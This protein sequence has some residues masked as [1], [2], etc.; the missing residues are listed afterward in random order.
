MDRGLDGIELEQP[1]AASLR[2]EM[3]EARLFAASLRR[4]T[5]GALLKREKHPSHHA[6]A[7]HPCKEEAKALSAAQDLEEQLPD[8]NAARKAIALYEKAAMC[9]KDPAM[10]A[11]A[12]YRGAM[13][14]L[15]QGDCA[16]AL[17]ALEHL[18]EGSRQYSPR[19][20]YWVARCQ[21]KGGQ[22]QKAALT[23]ARLLAEQPFSYHAL[24]L[25]EHAGM[26]PRQLMG[27]KAPIVAL[28]TGNAAWDQEVRLAELLLRSNEDSAARR[29]LAALKSGA[30]GVG[31]SAQLY[32]SVLQHRA[33][34]Y[35]ASFMTL[36][37]ILRQ[38]QGLLSPEVLT[39]LYPQPYRKLVASQARGQDPLLITALMRQESSFNPRARSR[40]G[41][42][43]LMQL[44]PSTV[45]EFSISAVRKLEKPETNIRYGARYFRGLMERFD[46]KIGL[47]LAAYNAGY[48]KVARWMKRY[49][50]TDLALF[51]DLIPYTETRE[52][53]SIIARN[54]FWYRWMEA[55]GRI[56][57]A[58][59]LWGLPVIVKSTA[60]M[61]AELMNKAKPPLQ[62]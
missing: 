62:P 22:K 18:I 57:Q 43:G 47:A 51:L 23:K 26:D 32:I 3:E 61:A 54:H 2:R 36:A 16:G 20:L 33:G 53:V 38:N 58:T 44:M 45:R 15:W 56:P 5:L 6:K 27:S 37:E 17:P 11:K 12:R 39:L 14:A 40:A 30:A 24:L 25:A 49:P 28:R 8:K 31:L 29:V 46:G 9:G 42:R 7:E 34:D 55:E 35:H 48:G 50:T 19:A 13:L 21:E 59:R 52:Y 1:R 60:P 10:V 4:G 41:A